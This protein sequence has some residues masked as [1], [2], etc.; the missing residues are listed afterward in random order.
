MP[1]RGPDEYGSSVTEELRE[2]AH[3]LTRLLCYVLNSLTKSARSALLKDSKELSDWWE[4]HERVDLTRKV[5]EYSRQY[6]NFN[7]N[8]IK[9][10]ISSGI[11]K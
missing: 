6:P 8:E 1:C 3:K 10:M 11:L 9:K 5:R 4:E 7:E 2:E